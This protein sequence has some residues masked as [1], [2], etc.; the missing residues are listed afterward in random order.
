MHDLIWRGGAPNRAAL[1]GYARTLKLD[2]DRF[3][4]AL[5]DQRH[6]A[7]IDRD[8]ALADAHA[9][10]ATPTSVINGHTVVGSQPIE[11]FRRVI[12]LAL[13]Q[14]RPGAPLR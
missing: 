5:D 11:E 7:T 8:V 6:D 14:G 1:L 9:I 3:A 13:E 4:R 12:D 10:P 2:S